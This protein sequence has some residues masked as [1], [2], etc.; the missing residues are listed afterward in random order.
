MRIPFSGRSSANLRNEWRIS[1]ISLKKSRWSASIFNMISIFGKKD[2]KLFVYSQASVTKSSGPPT[3]IFPPMESSIPPTE[4]VGFFFSSIRDLRQHRG[5]RCL[6]VGTGYGDGFLIVFHEL[7][8]KLCSGK[9]R[10]ILRRCRRVLRVIR[11]TAAVYTTASISSVMFS[12]R[13]P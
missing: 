13:C 1:S 10:Q 5:R 11:W 7:S 2:R 6:S 9:D 4:I 3:R 8:E 12:A